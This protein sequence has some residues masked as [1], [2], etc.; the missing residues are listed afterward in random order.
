MSNWSSLSEF[1]AMGGYA[2]FVWGSYGVTA[3]CMVVEVVLLLRR[4]RTLL[5]RLS[6]TNRVT[7]EVSKSNEVQT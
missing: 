4:K 3:L 1:L 7:A 6:R 2:L 5:Q